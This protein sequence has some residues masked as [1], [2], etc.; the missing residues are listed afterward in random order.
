M[1]REKNQELIDYYKNRRA[2]LL[3]A[4]DEPPRLVPYGEA[5]TVSW[6]EEKGDEGIALSGKM[7]DK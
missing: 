2:W 7:M 1:G 3:Y 4:D 6:K 5:G